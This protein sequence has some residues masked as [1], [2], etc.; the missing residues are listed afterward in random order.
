[1]IMT[2]ASPR[3]ITATVATALTIRATPSSAIRFMTKVR[4]FATDMVSSIACMELFETAS[5][6]APFA[7]QRLVV[8]RRLRERTNGCGAGGVE[9][10]G[11]HLRGHPCGDDRKDPGHQA[12]GHGPPQELTHG[13]RM[14]ADPRAAHGDVV[15]VVGDGDRRADGEHEDRRLEQPAQP[16]EDHK[17][18]ESP[19][20][21][22]EIFTE[23]LPN[24]PAH[25][26]DTLPGARAETSGGRA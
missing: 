3:P 23:K 17:G 5:C 18:G 7:A 25:G 11:G 9:D 21:V 26:G 4:P 14:R 1:M 20:A 6:S 16:C 8:P 19:P 22:G 12:R 10:V 24:S 15:L 13:D 2:M